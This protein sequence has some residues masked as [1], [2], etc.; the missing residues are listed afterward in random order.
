MPKA[1]RSAAAV[2][3]GFRVVSATPL[4]VRPYFIWD[5]ELKGALLLGGLGLDKP[6]IGPGHCFADG[7]SVSGIV[8]LPLDIGLLRRPAA[9]GA[10]YGR[11]P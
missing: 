11:A 4:L 10:H 5:L 9:S 1:A 7:L 8:L 2:K 6:H 3:I